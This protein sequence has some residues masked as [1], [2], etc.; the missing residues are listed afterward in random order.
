MFIFL[1]PMRFAVQT[2]RIFPSV[3][4]GQIR[5]GGIGH[6]GEHTVYVV[7]KYLSTNQLGNS[8]GSKR[9]DLFLQPPILST[10]EFR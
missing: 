5:H 10:A 4:L 6:L 3:Y 8:G 1:Q 2:L 9:G 7:V